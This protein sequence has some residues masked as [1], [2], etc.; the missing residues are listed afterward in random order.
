M[1]IYYGVFRYVFALA[2][3][4]MGYSGTFLHLQIGVFEYVF[5]CINR[6]KHLGMCLYVSIR[7]FRYIF[8]LVS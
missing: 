7:I 1:K 4:R 3:R 8:A 2:G 6:C 5:V